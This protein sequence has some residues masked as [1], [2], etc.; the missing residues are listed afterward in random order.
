MG[1]R[2]PRSHAHN[3]ESWASASAVRDAAESESIRGCRD[4][5]LR[6]AVAALDMI[7]LSKPEPRIMRH[8]LG[9]HEWT[10]IKPM[11]RLKIEMD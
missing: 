5:R 8:E 9:D 3:R 6:V 1:L 7:Q 10:A 4:R 2:G 11:Q